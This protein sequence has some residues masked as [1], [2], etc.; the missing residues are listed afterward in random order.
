MLHIAVARCHSGRNVLGTELETCDCDVR[1]TGVG[2][3]FFRDGYCSTGSED[4]GVHTICAVVT[5]EFLNFSR[6]AGNDLITPHPEY[7]FPGLK[8]GDKWCL[9]ASRWMEA[10]QRGKAPKVNL[11]ASHEKSLQF[12]DLDILKLYSHTP[13]D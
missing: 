2:T 9:C 7:N 5:K 11:R 13:I 10:Y 8:E 4:R 1:G 12:A 6:Q 3:G